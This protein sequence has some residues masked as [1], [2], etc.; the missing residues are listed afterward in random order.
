MSEN[1][2]YKIIEILRYL[3]LYVYL[4]NSILTIIS[5][6]IYITLISINLL[7][8]DIKSISLRLINIRKNLAFS[9]SAPYSKN[10]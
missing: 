3:Q 9:G 1:I 4:Y 8:S 10:N 7:P 6:F 2:S 5:V